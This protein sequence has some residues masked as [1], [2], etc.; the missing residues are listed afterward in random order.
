MA[1]VAGD[2]GDAWR[3]LAGDDEDA[4][5]VIVGDDEDEVVGGGWYS[6]VLEF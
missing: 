2:D 5:T 4:V 1:V 6:I 3:L